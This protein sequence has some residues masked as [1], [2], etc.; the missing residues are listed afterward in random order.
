M[1]HEH[2][3]VVVIL[4]LRPD[5]MIAAWSSFAAFSA[6]SRQERCPTELATVA[7]NSLKQEAI[8]ETMMN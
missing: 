4:L 5:G 8:A 3:N 2:Q 1:A 7:A 6:K